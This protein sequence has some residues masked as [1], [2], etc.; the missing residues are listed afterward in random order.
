MCRG[1]DDLGGM[2]LLSCTER[3]SFDVYDYNYSQYLSVT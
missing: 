1:I 2:V 3:M